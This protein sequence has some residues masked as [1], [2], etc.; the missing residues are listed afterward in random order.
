MNGMS[1]TAMI[2]SRAGAIIPRISSQSLPGTVVF[3]A[4]APE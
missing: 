1:E 2:P 4:I 3:A